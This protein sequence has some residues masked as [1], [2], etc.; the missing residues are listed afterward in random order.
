MKQN[1]ILL[2]CLCSII[3]LGACTKMLDTVQNGVVSSD[4]FYEGDEACEEAMAEVYY[5][6]ATVLHSMQP[7]SNPWHLKTL[8]S[9][10]IY[11]GGGT[12][13]DGLDCR[14]INEYQFDANSV[15]IEGV[16]AGMYKIIYKANLVSNN[17]ED[18]TT[19]VAKRNVAE[20]K[21]FRAWA[22]FQLVTLWGTAPVVTQASRSDYKEANATPSELWK[23]IEDDLGE[24]ISSGALTSKS[25]IDDKVTR[26]TKE[27]AQALLGKAYVFQEK[28]DD[29][30]KVL[31]QV[32]SSNKY[33]LM[34]SY[35]DYALA[36]NNNN[37]EVLFGD[38][39]TDDPTVTYGI[40]PN[41]HM[42]PSGNFWS[43]I[44]ASG[45][46]MIG[47]GWIHPSEHIVAAF[48]EREDGSKRFKE[49]LKSYEDIS[50]MGMTIKD[51]VEAYANCGYFNW[52]WR[53]PSASLVTGSFFYYHVQFP[54]MKYNE[55]LLLDAE[56]KIKAHG[57]GS[58]DA[59]INKIRSRAG[60][61]DLSG[62]GM[63]TLMDE[64]ELECYMDG[65][66][67]EDLVRW[68]KAETVLKDQGKQIPCFMGLNADGTYNIN[69]ARYTNPAYGFKAKHALMP[70]P[71][72]EL[73]VNPHM[74]QN[75]NWR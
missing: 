19:Q 3:T 15:I 48:K 45:L 56:A 74:V 71:Q 44:P 35:A 17:F 68:G 66:R 59:L 37:K 20:A 61:P 30:E 12:R 4:T 57:N 14:Y 10:E 51:G 65:V 73:D 47:F 8:L 18:S 27:Y 58:G 29:A 50:A 72:H 13:E 49:T 2:L 62:V 23:A 7:Y 26:V 52:K 63:D 28:W 21:V 43:N 40:F 39:P 6:N 22:N 16:Y 55:V 9:D 1:H 75:E 24:A 5:Q 54:L 34:D 67:F 64:K 38:N 25:G 46:S 32:V 36:S 69:H 53:S 31:D 33:G 70:I 41:V 42:A 11:H 60:L